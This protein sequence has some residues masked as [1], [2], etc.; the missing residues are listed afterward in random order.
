MGGDICV[1]SEPGKGST[2]R[3]SLMLS[4]IHNLNPR[5]ISEPSR[6]IYGYHGTRRK[7]L[8]VDDDDS[9]RQLIRAMLSPLGFEVCEL[10]NS[11]EVAETIDRERPDLLLLDVSMPGMDGW[12]V[13][14]QVRKEH[15]SLPVI[16]VSADAREGHHA[17]D[18]PTLHNG[19]IIKPVRLSLLLEN[20]ARV[21]ALRWRHEQSPE[22]LA[23]QPLPDPEEFS[24]PPE[25]YRDQLATL[26]R[27]G[28]RKGL[29]EVLD[30]MKHQ[31]AGSPALREELT[32]LINDFQFDKILTL[33]EAEH[34]E[35]S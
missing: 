32:Q 20:I 26:A 1:E 25:Q 16:M 27:I 30:A 29:L 23:P 35:V 14:K 6:T 2:F 22:P 7:L 13:L 21:L 3:V 9:H 5:S 31:N 11:L 34:D 28:H 10:A 24:L 18:T 4:S 17:P 8:V 19:Y 15:H 12:Q 33:L